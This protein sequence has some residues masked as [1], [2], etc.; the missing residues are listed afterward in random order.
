MYPHLRKSIYPVFDYDMSLASW[1]ALVIVL[2]SMIFGIMVIIVLRKLG[3][4]AKPKP[5]VVSW[6]AP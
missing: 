4:L 1:L 6:P 2:P 3:I 5:I